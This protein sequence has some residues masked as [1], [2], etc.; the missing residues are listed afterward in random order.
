MKLT[1]G[2]MSKMRSSA[3]YREHSILDNLARYEYRPE[4]GNRIIRFTDNK[5]KSCEYSL[6]QERWTN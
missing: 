5:G 6:A 1:S 3:G 4:K 2:L